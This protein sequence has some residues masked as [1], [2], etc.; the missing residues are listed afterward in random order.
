[1]PAEEGVGVRTY[2]VVIN[3]MREIVAGTG[4]QGLD[5][6]DDRVAVAAEEQ[7]AALLVE[8]AADRRRSASSTTK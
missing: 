1:M 5:P 3:R 4:V 2:L 6:L 8:G 7:G